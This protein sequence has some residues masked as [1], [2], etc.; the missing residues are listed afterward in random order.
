MKILITNHH[1]QDFAGSETYTF[2][3]AKGLKERDHQVTVLTALAGAVA[4]KLTQEG[5]EVFQNPAELKSHSFDVI[6]AH[7]NVMAILARNAFPK[8]PMIYVC[9]GIAPGLEEPPSIDLSLAAVTGVSDEVVAYLQQH[10]RIEEPVLIRNGVDL[11]RFASRKPISDQLKTVLII[12]NRITG[13]VIKPLLEA[14]AKK[15]LQVLHIGMGSQSVW[16]TEDVIAEADMVVS[17]GRGALESMACGRAVCI[18]DIHGGDGL[19]TEESYP[20]IRKHNFS[21]RRFA[22]RYS[23][24]NFIEIFEAYSPEMGTINRNIAEENHSLASMLDSFEDLYRK[25]VAK[26]V[27]PAEPIC[28]KELLFYQGYYQRMNVLDGVARKLAEENRFQKQKLDEMGV[29]VRQLMEQYQA[30]KKQWESK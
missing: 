25:A 13:E 26:Q 7:H 28:A 16:E 19:I 29:K 5:V 18:Y 20:E 24:E 22:N 9:H 21:G 6:H 14:A 10:H 4:E 15:N 8:T 2:A 30:E 11:E 12:S 17:L 1:L 27:L 3:L 23:E